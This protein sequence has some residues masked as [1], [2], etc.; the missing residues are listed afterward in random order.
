MRTIPTLETITLMGEMWLTFLRSTPHPT[1]TECEWLVWCSARCCCLLSWY[2]ALA[3]V[4]FFAAS[5]HLL[6][7]LWNQKIVQDLG[8]LPLMWETQMKLLAVAWAS[9]GE[10]DSA[11]HTLSP[12]LSSSLSLPPSNPLIPSLCLSPSLHI[13]LIPSISQSLTLSL[14]LILSFL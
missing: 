11:S 14:T 8:S 5:S 1:D 9:P 13:C 6:L 7:S 4:W 3:P 2:P 10:Y 12:P